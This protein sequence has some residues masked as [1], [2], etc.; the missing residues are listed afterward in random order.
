MNLEVVAPLPG[1]VL[2]LADVPDPV[3]AQAMVGPGCAIDP[4]RGAVEAVAPV[5]GRIVKL[6]PHAYVVVGEDGRGVLV[7]L[8]LDTVQLQGEGFR[9]LAEEGNDVEAG[10]PVVAW[11][12]AAVEAGG[13][14][15]VCPV[16]ALDAAPEALAGLVTSGE[17]AIGATLFTWE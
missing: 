11:D 15:P 9:L 12:T 17:V 6:H 10:T 14:S 2:P 5:A 1:K 7:H 3:F 13:R 16:I 4:P 8:G